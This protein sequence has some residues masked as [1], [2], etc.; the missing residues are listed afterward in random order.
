[1]RSR[2]ISACVIYVIL[3]ARWIYYFTSTHVLFFSGLSQKSSAKKVHLYAVLP[4]WA[5]DLYLHGASVSF[6]AWISGALL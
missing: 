5:V 6:R 3:I 2:A 1:M 4:T